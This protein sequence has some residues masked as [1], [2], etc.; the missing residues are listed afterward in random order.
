MET[1]SVSK[2]ET[3]TITNTP[4]LHPETWGV[5]LDERQ[6]EEIE[7]ART[8]LEQFDH[9]TDGHHRLRTLAVLANR[10][11]VLSRQLSDVEAILKRTIARSLPQGDPFS[12]QMEYEIVLDGEVIG[13]LTQRVRNI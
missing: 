3:R 8:Y 11:E 6:L 5:E 2:K 7:F 10:V 4:T 9:G 1:G 12:L 13:R